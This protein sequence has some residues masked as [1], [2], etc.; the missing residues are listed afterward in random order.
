VK[1]PGSSARFYPLEQRRRQW[2]NGRRLLAPA[3]L[4]LLASLRLAAGGQAITLDG[5]SGGRVFEGLG[6]LSA[7]AS[8]R[9]LLD[10]PEP[11]RSQV[12]DFLFKPGFGAAFQ[13]LKV[14]M[15]GDVNSTDGTEPSHARTPEEFEHPRR[16]YF[17]RGYEW[18]LMQEAR[19]RNPAL[20]LDVLQWG[21]PGWMGGEGNARAKFFSRDNADFIAAF[22]RGA[23]QYHGL[24]VD[25]CGIWNETPH[26]A[27][28]IKRLRQTLD[29]GGLGRVQIVA[30]D[31]V[32][33]KPWEIAREMLADPA[34]M[35]AVQ[36]IG[37]H[38]PRGKST[39]EALQ[40]GKPLW[41][42]EDG[43]WRGDWAGA[44][45]LAQTFNRN[46]IQGRMTK[47]IIWSLVSSYY[48]LLPLP[49]SGPMLAKEPW[50]GHYEV[51]PA[52][53]AIAHTTQFAQPGWR[54]LDGSCGALDGGGSFVTL[55]APG[56]AG[57]Y[58]VIIETIEARTAQRLELRLAGG[59]SRRPLRVWRSNERSQFARLPDLPAGDG[60]F[61]LTLEPGA[62]YSLTTTTGQQ[63]GDAGPPPPAAEF[64]CPYAD[65]FATAQPGRYA[66]YF[67]DQGGVFEVAARP[68]GRGQCLRQVVPRNGIDWPGHPTPQPYTLIGS[69]KWRNYEV[70]ADALIEGAG[71][72]SLWG[73]VA[74]SYQTA[75]PAKGYWLKVGADGQ[76]QLHAFTNRLAGGAVAFGP[77]Q[78][79]QLKLRF[80]GVRV[81]VCV[82]GAELQTVED[83]SLRRGMAGL[84][85]GW[86]G[87][88]FA[89]FRVR[90]L[91]G[92]EPANLALGKRATASSQWSEA[93][94]A[95]AATDGNAQTR[96]NAAAGK[97]VGEWLEVDLGE[98]TRF[99][100]VVVTQ[101]SRRITHY[102]LEGLQG[103]RWT[104]LCS[105]SSAGQDEWTACFPA[106]EARKVRLV[107]LEVTAPPES[108]P[109][110]IFELE[111][112]LED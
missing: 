29:G 70:S 111:A 53:W 69:P 74:A 15:G 31:E 24:N 3:L 16:G 86:N 1:Y 44:C 66:R 46:Y 93:Y 39:P 76:W 85:S 88:E 60:T 13:H 6:A 22:L 20:L 71:S 51:Q 19:K 96:W 40:T 68:D 9:L 84:G 75:Q 73:R 47:T 83:G 38:Y 54:Y 42:S 72:V 5:Q 79:H 105:G 90:P 45:A 48:D 106:V 7:G 94:A 2:S 97:A 65:G 95:A 4:F 87:A 49:N 36:V 107:V 99:N 109:P 14:E 18:W 63:K 61:S 58:S 67:S 80:H 32:G 30:A 89:D 11:Q 10:Y 64:P 102:R 104:E 37:A 41:A 110:S 8:S 100:T 78:W 112:Y 28:W 82:D 35:Q 57:D 62:I 98:P 59:L 101:F 81:T 108:N 23:R 25:Y 17:E 33:D 50:S 21:A 12:L 26:D 52:I 103:Q 77:D 56:A 91:G 92:P 55:R 43:P 34:L 27:G